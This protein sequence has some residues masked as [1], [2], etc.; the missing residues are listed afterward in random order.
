MPFKEKK[1]TEAAAFLLKLRGG[2]MSYLKLIKLLYLADREA[3]S[4]WGFSLTN[5]TH[6]SMPHGPVVSNTYNLMIDEADKPFWSRYITPPLG[7]YEIALREDCPTDELSR[8]E[9]KLLTEI[10]EQY[11]HLT[12]WQLRDFTHTLPE[13]HDPHGSSVPISVREILQATGVSPADIEIITNE[14]EGAEH[15]DQILGSV[16]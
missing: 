14:I 11:G 6:V 10:F 1:A 4:R 9:E 16:A 7:E 15:T 2:K 5:D 8:A 13:W 12:R 3:L